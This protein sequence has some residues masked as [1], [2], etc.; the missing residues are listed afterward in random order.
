MPA[1]LSPLLAPIASCI[2]PLL[3]W[4]AGRSAAANTPSVVTNQEKKNE[5][6]AIDKVRADIAA[7]D[8]NAERR[9]NS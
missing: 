2:A 7:D 4:L 3:N 9:D 6:K 8:I 1:W 5:Q